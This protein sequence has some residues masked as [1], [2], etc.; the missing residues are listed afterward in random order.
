MSNNP[1][2]EDQSVTRAEDQSASKD[3]TFFEKTKH[4]LKR[5]SNI[6][7]AA[8]VGVS[9]VMPIPLISACIIGGVGMFIKSD[10]DSFLGKAINFCSSMMKGIGVAGLG[11]LAISA[12]SVPALATIG[13]VA[14]GGYLAKKG[15]DKVISS[16]R[17]SKQIQSNLES[18][19]QI[20]SSTR[21]QAPETS[22]EPR[23]VAPQ[24]PPLRTQETQN[25]SSNSKLKLE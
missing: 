6:A 21:V 15:Y 25:R 19:R 16:R 10:R 14:L 2:T 8:G 13:G 12:V 23:S 9:L 18:G 20:E 7:M 4:F 17:N 3:A 5:P 11:L 24:T 1:R 22:R